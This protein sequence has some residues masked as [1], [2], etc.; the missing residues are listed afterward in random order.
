MSSVWVST[1]QLNTFCPTGIVGIYGAVI[2][3]KM[4]ADVSESKHAEKYV[5]V[6][7]AVA[8]SIIKCMYRWKEST[9]YSIC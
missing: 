3:A 4:T 9:K 7:V 1:S 2:D 6:D 8:H 5:Q